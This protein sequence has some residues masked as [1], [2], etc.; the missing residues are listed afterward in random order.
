[1]QTARSLGL[2]HAVRPQCSR[3]AKPAL[4][5]QHQKGCG[6]CC[7]VREGLHTHRGAQPMGAEWGLAGH[8]L[9]QGAWGSTEPSRP[10]FLTLHLLAAREE[11][12]RLKDYKYLN[13]M[14]FG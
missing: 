4:N 3:R 7:G 11:V 12:R 9:G 5:A 6:D 13:I 1:M 10:G 14:M 2:G 8:L